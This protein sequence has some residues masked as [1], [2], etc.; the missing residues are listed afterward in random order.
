MAL[1][2]AGGEVEPDYAEPYMERLRLQLREAGLLDEDLGLTDEGEKVFEALSGL[3][4][5]GPGDEL[6]RLERMAA[7]DLSV[8][9]RGRI[10]RE[11]S[12]MER[13]ASEE[14]LV[15]IR[16]VRDSLESGG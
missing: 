9:E 7:G 5:E 2:D 14:E 8:V 4:D 13:T 6:S 3:V 10:L 15:R 12:A 1:L 16:E 11:L